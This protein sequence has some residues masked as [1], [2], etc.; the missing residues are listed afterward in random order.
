[1]HPMH[2]AGTA[3]PTLRIAMVT[4]TYPPD[5]NGV[6]NSVARVVEGLAQRGHTVQMVRP[7]RAGG[8]PPPAR[9]GAPEVLTRGIPIPMYGQLQMGLPCRRQLIEAWTQDRPAVV[10]IATEGPLGWS[11]LQAARRLGLP[12]CSD[13]RTNFHAYSAFYGIGWLRRPIMGY[14]RRFHNGC[15][16]TMV[17]TDALRQQLGASGFG[18]LSVVERGVDTR[19]FAPGKRSA[20]LRQQWGVY[21]DDL[22][23]L[24]V[25]RLAPEK[26][27][28]VLVQAFQR[29]HAAQP[30]ARLVVVGDGPGR[31]ALQTQFPRAI[32]AGFRSGEE[33]A[34]YYASSDL[35]LFPSLTETYGNVTLEAMASGLAVVAFDDAAAGRLIRHRVNGLLAP[36][37]NV[38]AFLHSAG[39][40]AL[41]RER[42]RHLGARARA[43]VLDQGWD[44]VID[45]LEGI[46]I[47]SI[48]KTHAPMVWC[49]TPAAGGLAT[50][51]EGS[52]AG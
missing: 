49:G 40:A 42:R 10:H 12:V 33:L 11:A 50:R 9:P 28:P 31:A 2:K 38:P 8:H 43:T 24:H 46:Y 36:R 29:L 25:G 51:Q 5:V 19:L 35:F 7:R 14:L 3:Q 18:G 21:E 22:V 44:R 37:G 20:A 17:P 34:A 30:R 52:A 32:F 16:A 45:K 47:G 23:V 41:D 27:L 13:F 6:A 48:R 15:H 39:E 26:N 1:M 4:E